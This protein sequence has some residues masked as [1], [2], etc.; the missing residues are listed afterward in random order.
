M[1][2]LGHALKDMEPSITH[3]FLNDVEYPLLCSGI[4]LSTMVIHRLLLNE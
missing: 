4:L 1:Y 2:Y 3:H